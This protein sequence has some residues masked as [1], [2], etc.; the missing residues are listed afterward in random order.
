[1]RKLILH[2]GMH[3][4]GT[5]SIQETLG[6]SREFLLKNNIWYPSLEEVNH[7]V[8][9]T[10]IFSNDPLKDITF[11][12]KEITTLEQ[13]KKEQNALKRMWIEEF[14]KVTCDTVIM[15]AEGC[16]ML[17]EPRV[18][19][20]K[21]FLDR[22]FD[23]YLI[24]MYVRDPRSYFISSF[25]QMLK[26]SDVSFENFSFRKPNKLYT[27]R[28]VPYINVFGRD[29]I[30]VRPFSQAAFKNGDLIDD[31]FDSVG[32]HIDTSKLHK[33]RTNESLGY[34]TTVLLSELNKRYPGFINGKY[35]PDRGLAKNIGKIIEIFSRVDDKKLL[36]DLHFS[37][38]DAEYINREIEYINQFL[39]ESDRFEKV[40]ASK[41]PNRFPT[42][43]DLDDNYLI[44]VIN[45]Y[46][47]EIETLLRGNF[48]YTL[49]RA[50]KKKRFFR[51]WR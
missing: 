47:K 1:M 12:A 35:N 2:I 34:N 24:L 45:E 18:R 30:V 11:K 37:Q 22:F 32:L 15:S 31:F 5:S 29:K 9:F 39:N 50:L 48:G 33:I 38:E 27:R 28:L 17:L 10:P 46:N 16:S 42:L 21:E 36:L 25:Q 23:D 26:H 7:T 3:K 51:F 49:D 4:T 19:E 13:A 14:R 8:N 41:T 20:M 44:D 43:K 40:E 6:K